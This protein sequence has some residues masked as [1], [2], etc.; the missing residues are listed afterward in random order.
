MYKEDRFWY[1]VPAREA[2]SPEELHQESRRKMT[3]CSRCSE[4]KSSGRA[5]DEFEDG[6]K[7]CPNC[8][9]NF[10]RKFYFNESDPA[11]ADVVLRWAASIIIHE[12]Q[13]SRFWGSL[14]PGNDIRAWIY[15]TVTRG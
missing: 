9:S 2:S 10:C 3:M 7:Y 6:A 8:A 4:D 5:Y 1:R 15:E 11:R 13:L 14:E 12:K